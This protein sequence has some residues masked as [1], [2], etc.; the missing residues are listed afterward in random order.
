MPNLGIQGGPDLYRGHTDS[1]PFG[2]AD[3]VGM[4]DE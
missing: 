3:T 4:D 1:Q 2:G